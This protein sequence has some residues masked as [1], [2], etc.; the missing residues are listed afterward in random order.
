MSY[1]VT[2]LAVA[3]ISFALAVVPKVPDAFVED[4]LKVSRVLIGVSQFLAINSL[5]ELAEKNM[6]ELRALRPLGKFLS[7][8]LVVFFTF[9]QSLVMGHLVRKGLFA[10]FFD[11]Q[12]KW[13][14]ETAV[15]EGVLD[16]VVIFEMFVVS[17]CHFPIFPPDDFVHLSHA[18]TYGK[19]Y[20]RCKSTLASQTLDV[21]NPA[22][23]L[24]TVCPRCV[25]TGGLNRTW[26]THDGRRRFTLSGGALPVICEDCNSGSSSTSEEEEDDEDSDTDGSPSEDTRE[27]G[28]AGAEEPLDGREAGDAHQ[29]KGLYSKSGEHHA[30]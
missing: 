30:G 24:A 18:E 17:M 13:G 8:K 21:F 11:N 4:W 27:E 23:V 5:V 2:G 19:G 1:V 25:Q 14:T 29:V 28:L 20:G 6:E 10:D 16:V 12:E 22:D 7:V 9:W 15:G 3:V 26:F